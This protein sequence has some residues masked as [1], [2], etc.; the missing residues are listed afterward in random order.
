MAGNA[1]TASYPFISDEYAKE[2]S[3]RKKY[4]KRTTIKAKMPE[5]GSFSLPVSY[6]FAMTGLMT[7]WNFKP[8]RAST[9]YS[10]NTSG[11]QDALPAPRRKPSML[12]TVVFWSCKSS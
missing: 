12:T 10:G 11:P 7:N 2:K 4:G 3:N 8:L 1:V 6:F 9:Q 5:N